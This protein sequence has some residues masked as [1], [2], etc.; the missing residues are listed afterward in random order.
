MK[1]INLIKAGSSLI[2]SALL[3][4]S[5]AK[6][7]DKRVAVE[8]TNFADKSFVQVYNGV[9]GS[10]RN[11]VYVDGVPVNGAILSYNAVFPST[12]ANFS[13]G[14]G[15]RAFLVRDTSS[16]VLTQPPLSFAENLQAGSYYTIFMY[17]SSI[18]PKK[19]I[20]TNNIQVPADT[21]ARLRFANFILN[22]TALPSGFD[23]FSVKRNAVIFSNVRE[24]EITD[25]I[26]YASASTDTF[27]VR[28]NG[29]TSNLQN[30]DTTGKPTILNIQATLNPTRFR[31]YTLVWRGSYRGVNNK[32]T[33]GA[34]IA[35]A[36]GLSSFVNY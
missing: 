12:P 20:V 6:K 5:C 31:N 35:A 13:I 14:N 18:S 32:T 7:V 22:P 26:P 27:Y 1:A 30:I 11:Y 8:N 2:I 24:T 10:S 19:K 3:V 25:Y 4:V 16:T 29:S 21:T 36:R 17:D 9:V 23:I 28:L 33:T 15:F 34:A